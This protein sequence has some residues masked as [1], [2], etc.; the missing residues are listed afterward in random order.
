MR[1]NENYDDEE[2]E[3]HD[4]EDEDE[5]GKKN[6]A[7]E[8]GDERARLRQETKRREKKVREIGATD[9]NAAERTAIRTERADE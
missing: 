9:T 4:D 5:H 7:M 1:R 2:E 8:I 6:I 3:K